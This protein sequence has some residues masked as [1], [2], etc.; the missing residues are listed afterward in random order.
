V[1]SAIFT[2]GDRLENGHYTVLKEV[3]LGGMGVVYHSR[4]EL[5][6]RD[7]AIKMLL[8]S[9]MTDKKNVDVFREEARLAA[10]LEHPNIVTV[11]DVGAEL[12]DDM[13]HYFVAMEYLP[14]GTLASR[15]NQGPLPL[16]H[17]LNWMKQLASGLSFAHKRG[18]IHQ[19]I[20]A[21]NIFITHEGDL[22]IGDFGLARLLPGRVYVNTTQKGMGT[23]AYMSPE[24]CRGEPQD[25]R[26]DIYSMGI[27]FYEMCTGQLP[28]RA[29]GMIE[30]AMKHTNAPI[31]SPKRVNSDVPDVLER[32]IKRMIAKAPEE[33]FKSMADVLGIIDD[34]IFEMR[35]AHMGLTPRSLPRITEA[36]DLQA[37]LA[38]APS[39]PPPPV[40]EQ[41]SSKDGTTSGADGGK[42][43]FDASPFLNPDDEGS[44]KKVSAFPAFPGF[45]AAE[46]NYGALEIDNR[47]ALNFE[48]R[49]P[50][51]PNFENH[52]DP[53]TEAVWAY[54][55]KGPIGWMASPCISR[56]ETLVY[57]CS[58]D[59]RLYA[60]DSRTG[61][62]AFSYDAKAPLLSSPLITE[63]KLILTDTQGKVH[64]LD[65][66]T[67]NDIWVVESNSN[68]VASMVASPVVHG[69]SVIVCDRRGVVTALDIR[70]GMKLWTFNAADAI[71]AAPRVH[72]DKLYFGTRGGQIYAI[73]CS[74]GK[75]LW[76][77]VAV[78][79]VLSTPVASVDA[80]YVGTQAGWFY[81]LEAESG[82]VMWES[83]AEGPISTGGVMVYTQVIFASQNKWLFCCEKY[84]GKLRWKV[85]LKGCPSA[86][87]EAVGSTVICIAKE[88]WLQAFDTQ[89]GKLAY[90]NF[91]KKDIESAP[92]LLGK[93]L[94]VGSVD[95]ALSCFELAQ[96]GRVGEAVPVTP[97]A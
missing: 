9:L 7:V 18:V 84:D 11:Y 71:V 74:T 38:S 64:A 8:P 63:E 52:K 20:K 81:A 35:V 49:T 83:Q 36:L 15:I 13:E 76:K 68:N 57:V 51:R 47:K 10:G 55:T 91:L 89:T 6:L 22:K 29:Q 12:R 82:R 41:S 4:D 48:R 69:H 30:M 65:P 90:E 95:G 96:Q 67:G 66:K 25:H 79:K 85:P 26:S 62:L 54:S 45:A 32:V 33:R 70:L 78:G 24:L 75:Q 28:Y 58:A 39:N 43:S 46:P 93:K 86:T 53:E 16:K 21:D 34:L 37:L 88:G 3:G 72:G 44:V 92:L 73:S 94:F 14:G 1:S 80:V 50:N 61:R 97:K 17:C 40:K 77:Y 42:T 60:V 23:P 5:L 56:D 2:K 19:D 59:G 27:L 87:L 31:P